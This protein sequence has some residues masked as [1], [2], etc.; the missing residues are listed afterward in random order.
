MKKLVLF[1]AA[2]AFGVNSKAQIGFTDGS[3][4]LPN[5]GVSSAIPIGISDMNNDGLDDI[6]RLDEGVDLSIEYQQ[7]DGSYNTL[8]IANVGMSFQWTISIADVDDNGYKDII[9][10]GI[11]DDI[12]LY[13][14]NADGSA[15]THTTIPQQFVIQGSNFV[16]IDNDGDVDFF[17]NSDFDNNRIF[18][19][20][21]NGVFTLNNNLIETNQAAGNYS[22][23]WTDYDNDGDIDVYSVKCFASSTDPTDDERINRLYQNDGSGNYTD[24]SA[25]AGVQTG[26]QSWA[27]DFADIDN[28]GDMDMF[29]VN[30]AAVSQLFENN[31]DGTFTDITTGSGVTS[32]LSKANLQVSFRDFDNDGYVDLL[33]GGEDEAIF[34]NNGDKTFTAVANPFPANSGTI[35]SYALGDL[36]DDGYVDIYAVYLTFVSS[37]SI[38]IAPSTDPDLMLLNS[39]TGNNYLKINLKGTTSNPDGIGARIRITGPWGTQIREVRS[40][41]SYG[42]MNSLTTH[43]GIGTANTIDSIVVTWPS[44]IVSNLQGTAANQTILIEEGTSVS[45]E[46]REHPNPNIAVFPNPAIEFVNIDFT[47]FKDETIQIRIIDLSGKVVYEDQ[48]VGGNF[49]HFTPDLATGNYLIEMNG[50]SLKQTERLV[51]E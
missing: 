29:L 3:S 49:Y 5:T 18:E 2:L 46:D 1:A 28:D 37:P 39:G 9:V 50:T 25:A 13:T 27:S 45:I 17:A 4:Q 42:I 48:V 6:I 15:Y 40:G 12:Q 14:A 30:H 20:D 22:T 34:H 31:G 24:V 26:E 19:N 44:G 47:G 51:I 36:D 32:D 33:I 41:E 8:A 35:N 43:F 21:G 11:F 7:T 38:A 10:A 23:L 16:D